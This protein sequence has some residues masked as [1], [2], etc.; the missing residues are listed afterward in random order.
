MKYASIRKIDLSNGDGIR[1]S[2]FLQGCS[3]HC[4]GCW[5][6]STWDFNSG[7]EL[8]IEKINKFIEISNKN[9]IKGVS[10]LG[11]EPFQQNVDELLS[12]L[13][14]LKQEVNKP[15]Y[16]WTG[17]TFN[18]IPSKYKPCLDYIDLI[19]DGRFIENLKDYKLKM[20]GSSNQ[21]IYKKINNIWTKNEG[22]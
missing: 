7:K 13:K 12:F 6:E 22:D 21:N 10:I 16:L 2:I 11:G 3:H 1:T 14:R 15:I 9:Y 20:R 5:N 18:A 19:V 4:K 17:Y 8:T